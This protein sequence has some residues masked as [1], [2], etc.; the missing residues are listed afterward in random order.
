MYQIWSR[1]DKVKALLDG[2]NG[3]GTFQ[4]GGVT[5]AARSNLTTDSD[6]A[7]RVT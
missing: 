4:D 7:R 5:L 1:S 2:A 6:R 3:F